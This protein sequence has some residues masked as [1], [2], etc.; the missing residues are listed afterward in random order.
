MHIELF[1]RTKYSSFEQAKQSGAAYDVYVD[2]D[3][4]Y[5]LHGGNG[6]DLIHA[7]SQALTMVGQRDRL[8]VV[9]INAMGKVI[10]TYGEG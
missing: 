3:E 6:A 5:G 4:R 2:I 9:L 10:E 7:M 8:G 1:D